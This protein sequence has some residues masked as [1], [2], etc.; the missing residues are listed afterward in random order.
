L[1][2]FIPRRFWPSGGQKCLN[3]LFGGSEFI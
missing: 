3:Q 2:F 1:I